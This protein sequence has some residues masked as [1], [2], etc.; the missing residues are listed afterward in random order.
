MKLRKAVAVLAIIG[1][2]GLFA[3][4]ITEVTTLVDEIQATTNV[5]VKTEL[6]KKLDATLL[7]MNKKDLAIAEKIINANLKEY[8]TMKK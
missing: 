2:T 3:S 4:G 8:K 5:N 1:V 6:V 7:A